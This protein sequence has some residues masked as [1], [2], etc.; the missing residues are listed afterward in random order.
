MIRF[1][2]IKGAIMNDVDRPATLSEIAATLGKDKSTVSRMAKKWVYTEEPAPGNPK[3]LY[4]LKDLPKDIRNVVY[5]ARFDSSTP[6]SEAENNEPEPGK[7]IDS[8]PDTQIA[9]IDTE[10]HQF[11]YSKEQRKSGL[12]IGNVMRFIENFE[13]TKIDAIRLLNSDYQ[14]GT[15]PS[16]LVW[17]MNNC[18]QKESGVKKSGFILSKDTIP[19]WERRFKKYGHYMPQ[20]RQKSQELKAWEVDLIKM[21]NNNPQKKPD[22]WMHEQLQKKY[23]DAVSINMVRYFRREKYSQGDW[24][25][26][27]HT[28]MQLRAKQAYQPRTNSG[29]EP[30]QEVHADGWTT[31]FTAPHPI[32]G[33]FVTY[34]LWD[35]HDVATR[36]IPPFGL[37]LTENFEVIAKGLENAIRDNG[38]MCILLTD[39]TKIIKNNAK[40]VGDPVKSIADKAG[41]TIK[42]PKTV[43]NA[44]ANG[45]AENF[46]TWI[47]K[48]AR[49]L[50]TY[51]AKK[52]D[53]MTL[54]RVKKI[55]SN[56]AKAAK[57]DD[58]ELREQLKMEAMKAGNGIVLDSYEELRDWLEEKRYKWNNKPHSALKKVRDS[59]TGK[60][61]YQTPQES[62]DECKANG[63][64]P[65]MMD[66]GHLADLF[67]VH[68]ETKVKRGF[69]TPYGGM[70]FRDPELDHWEG[71][72]VIVAYDSMNYERVWVKDL[73]GQLICIAPF[74]EATGYRSVTAYETAQE[75]RAK[76]QIKRKENQ[77]DSIKAKAGIEEHNIIDVVPSPIGL[78]RV[79]DEP[80]EH[81]VEAK[82]TVVDIE[83][84]QDE[85]VKQKSY[86]ETW[87][88]LLSDDEEDK[89]DE[90]IQN[91]PAE[92]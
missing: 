5:M 64:E 13:G 46:H 33:D 18:K 89:E 66:E 27:R 21:L 30:W 56:M 52:M 4:A 20:V 17:A 57:K 60:K 41:I 71:L 50:A 58:L 92:K 65:V 67:L 75:D 62:L 10:E 70:L 53:S 61:R 34:E 84:K 7:S 86:L 73:K 51:Q 69:V 45:I 14:A 29:M 28:G 77:I 63:W 85:E 83:P 78:K 1:T 15:L 44:Q 36:Y 35:F 26:G 39:S 38:V 55:T 22:T 72:K 80:I 48:E 79:E 23:G 76:A 43:G 8:I 40:F 16:P 2:N 3:R 74:V 54:R 11:L 59:E 12:A 68:K 88:M 32:T 25:K 47:D 82:L 87:S 91:K 81:V 37:G 90:S 31:H 19:K 42:H 9:L 49:E 24:I 6:P